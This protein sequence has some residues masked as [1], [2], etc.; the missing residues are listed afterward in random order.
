M[1]PR[2]VHILHGQWSRPECPGPN[3]MV[4]PSLPRRQDLPSKEGLCSLGP[5]SPAPPVSRGRSSPAAEGKWCSGNR[6][7][8][9]VPSTWGLWPICSVT[10]GSPLPSPSP[11]ACPPFRSCEARRETE[12]PDSLPALSPSTDSGSVQAGR[13]VGEESRGLLETTPCYSCAP[14]H[15]HQGCWARPAGRAGAQRDL[16]WKVLLA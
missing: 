13:L 9:W 15:T 14:T 11:T 1:G 12:E 3:L 6:P 5:L 4:F 7:S 2:R 10:W 16:F 8:L